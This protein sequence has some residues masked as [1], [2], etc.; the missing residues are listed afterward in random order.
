MKIHIFCYVTLCRFLNMSC[1]LLGIPLRLIK[2]APPAGHSLQKPEF[3]PGPVR[4]GFVV[5]SVALKGVCHRVLLFCPFSIISPMLNTDI[6]SL[7]TDGI[8]TC[9][10]S[11]KRRKNIV[12][13]TG[14]HVVLYYRMYSTFVSQNVFQ[15]QLHTISDMYSYLGKTP[16]NCRYMHAEINIRL[17]A[18]NVS[19]HS[20]RNFLSF[21]FLP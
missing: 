11:T 9:Y 10:T 8:V 12:H 6:H 1:V 21:H 20:V 7:A 2:K 3:N 14:P 13:S 18:E 17:D 15:V 4:V 19:Y 5:G 16:T